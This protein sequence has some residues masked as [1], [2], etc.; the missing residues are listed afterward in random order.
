MGE[1]RPTVV[2][3]GHAVEPMCDHHLECDFIPCSSTGVAIERSWIKS[4]GKVF[5]SSRLLLDVSS[6]M[7]INMQCKDFH[8]FLFT[9]IRQST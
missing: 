6:G 7:N 8:I 5:L 2:N 1:A 4:T 3:A 9:P